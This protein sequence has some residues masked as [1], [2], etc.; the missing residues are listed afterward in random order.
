MGAFHILTYLRPAL[1][2]LSGGGPQTSS[3]YPS[4]VAVPLSAEIRLVGLG[5]L[6]HSYSD[7][8]WLPGLNHVLWEAQTAPRNLLGHVGPGYNI[9][10]EWDGMPGQQGHGALLLEGNVH[11][12]I[13]AAHP[14]LSI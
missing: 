2:R 12:L 6:G 7:I 13:P 10:L 14:A 11:L 4:G 9:T 1:T 5:A 3:L 8:Q